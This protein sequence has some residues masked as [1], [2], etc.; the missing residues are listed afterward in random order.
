MEIREENIINIHHYLPHREPMLMADYILELTKEKVV[1]SF[2][3]LKDNIFVHNNHFIE[4]GLIENAAQT[5]SSIMGQSFFE[6][7][8]T[9]T[10]VIGFI[11]SMKKI[12]VFTLPKVGDT[13]IS[14]ASLISQFENIC[15]IFCE[16]FVGDELLLRAE[17]NL[18]IQQIQH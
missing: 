6:Q 11:T 12:E 13:I 5:C 10:K 14:K 4:A 16:T 3:I 9:G 18:F 15:H 8:G 17:I 7:T 1:T 2:E